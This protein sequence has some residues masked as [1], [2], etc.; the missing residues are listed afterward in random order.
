MYR[1]TRSNNENLKNNMLLANELFN[2]IWDKAKDSVRHRIHFDLRD[3]ENDDSQRMLNVLEI[4]TKIPIHRHRDTSEVVIILRG[5][6]RE[7]Y[8]DNQGNEIASYLLE[9]GSPIPPEFVF[10]KGCDIIC[11]CLE[12]G[13]VIF[14]SKNGRYDPL[15]TEEFLFK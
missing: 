4:D 7:V 3:S 10:L 1:Q 14:E 8:F 11:E 12:P 5:K 9:Y 6:V 2:T 13:S 15:S